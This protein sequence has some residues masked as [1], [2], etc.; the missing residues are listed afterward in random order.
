[1]PGEITL[2]SPEE[3]K[4]FDFAKAGFSGEGTF[5]WEKEFVPDAYETEVK[6]VFTPSDTEKK[7]YTQVEG[8]NEEKGP[9]D[10]HRKDPCG[11]FEEE[12]SDTTEEKEENTDQ[13]GQ[14]PGN[15]PEGE[16]TPSEEMETVTKNRQGQI[17]KLT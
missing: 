9:G 5:S 10:P 12:A 8:W 2:A 4:K 14:K 16:Q 17:K 13:N 6:V 1:M 11:V 7:D 15:S 3:I